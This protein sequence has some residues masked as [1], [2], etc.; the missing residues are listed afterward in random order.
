LT[1]KIA[2]NLT[3]MFNEHDFMNRF[4]AA[5]SCGFK[6]VEYLFPYDYP[7]E[8]IAEQ[9]ETQQLQQ[10][11]FD[12]PAGDWASGD[13]GIAVQPDRVGEFQDGVGL[14]IEY[15]KVLGCAR[16][17]CLAG[18]PDAGTEPAISERT[19]IEN[20]RFAADAAAE[21]GA[22]VLVEPLNTRDVPGTFVSTSAHGARIVRATGRTNVQ[23]QFDV[24]HTQIMEGDLA[25]NFTRLLP[26]IGHVQ[27]ADNPGRHEPGS[28]EINYP[29]VLKHINESGY[30][31]WIGA[32]YIPAGGTVSGLGWASEY[33]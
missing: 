16:L 4:A 6:G 28:G 25:P 17:T 19:M 27:I 5:A 8:A 20:L 9:L 32:E 21:I 18:I 12:F 31:G 14:A 23:L 10:V 29:F 22:K 30:D 2:A 13:R 33:L 24:Y 3:M 1:L 7:A 26:W 15:G 11:L